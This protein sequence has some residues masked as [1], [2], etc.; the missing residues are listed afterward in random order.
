MTSRAAI[1]TGI[2]A[3]LMAS[4]SLAQSDL[5][6]V[7]PEHSYEGYGYAISA[8]V[9]MEWFIRAGL[10]GH[11]A[12]YF[13]M[14]TRRE[15]KRLHTLAAT[16]PSFWMTDCDTT[17]A[18]LEAALAELGKHEPGS[19][20]TTSSIEQLPSAGLPPECIRIRALQYDSGVPEGKGKTYE[21]HVDGML[22]SHPDAANL[23]LHPN[24]SERLRKG[25]RRRKVEPEDVETFL[26]GFEF[27]PIGPV[28]D[29]THVFK[30]RLGGIAWD[31]DN[32]WVQHEL[33]MSMFDAQT[34]MPVRTIDVP[35]TSLAFALVNDRLWLTEYNN[36]KLTKIDAETGSVIASLPLPGFPVDIAY[37]DG[38]LWIA[39]GDTGAV[40]RVDVAE[41]TIA[42]TI[43]VG[44]G[45]TG[46]T[47]AFGSIWVASM[48]INRVF[49]I[50]PAAH[51]AVGRIDVCNRP[52]DVVALNGFI[53]AGCGIDG[54]IVK[55]DPVSDSIT[56]QY[57]TG[58]S[59]FYIAAGDNELWI[60]N[61]THP[62]VSRF[63]IGRGE[64][65]ANM[66]LGNVPANLCTSP[67]RAWVTE[68]SSGTLYRIVDNQ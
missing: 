5:Y 49:R 62:S 61:D 29:A 12:Q 44:T 59:P 23:V 32:I 17:E 9:G 63:D 2:T 53:W 60:S 24:Y 66:Y 48:N 43:L 21:I 1:W 68:F 6:P 14:P 42:D 26:R 18:C 11:Q 65:T 67:G 30:E 15:A 52:L 50:D 55:I 41:G 56:A 38:S 35:D 28:V 37:L 46:I 3:S 10:I 27:R 7:D 39:H 19:R 51:A 33:K 54:L 4:S 31:G 22:C 20:F 34:G 13:A 58:G 8:P 47:A 16:V 57:R 40:V 64:V 25:D 36:H 45:N